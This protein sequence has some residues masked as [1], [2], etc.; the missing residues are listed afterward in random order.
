MSQLP[1]ISG[2]GG[3]CDVTVDDPPKIAGRYTKKLIKNVNDKASTLHF[4]GLV[5]DGNVHSHIDHLKAMVTQAHKDGVKRLRVHALLDGR[6]VDPTSALNY[7]TPL[8]EFLWLTTLQKLRVV[9]PVPY[10]NMI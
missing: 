2:N 5:S 3:N 6:D 9:I 8:E 10:Y 1:W 7:I 4:I